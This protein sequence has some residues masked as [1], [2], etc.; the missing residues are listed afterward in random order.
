MKAEPFPA[1]TKN[2]NEAMIPYDRYTELL[3]KHINRTINAAELS[4]VAKFEA[5]QPQSCP[6]CKAAVASSFTPN[7]VIH[8]IEKCSVK[9]SES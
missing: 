1:A 5:A 2:K 6:K 8:D 7:R 3:S 4:D 9:K